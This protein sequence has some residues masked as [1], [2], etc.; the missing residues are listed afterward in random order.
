MKFT[1]TKSSDTV[2]LFK[3]LLSNHTKPPSYFNTGPRKL[4]ILHTRLRLGCSSLNDDLF[5][6]NI[7]PSNLCICGQVETVDHYLFNCPR[8]LTQRDVLFRHIIQLDGTLILNNHLLLFGCQA[9]SPALNVELFKIVYH[10]IDST[11]RFT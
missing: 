9:L 4:Q 1:F 8:Y 2:Q 6:K 7:S 5:R 10:Y 11:K 3:R